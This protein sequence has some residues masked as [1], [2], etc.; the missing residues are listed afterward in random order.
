MPPNRWPRSRHALA[1]VARPAH[2]ALALVSD[3]RW[4]RLHAL[5]H[6][7]YPLTCPHL[8]SFCK[9]ALWSAW[10]R[11]VS[12]CVSWAC[13]ASRT[14]VLGALPPFPGPPAGAGPSGCPPSCWS[15]VCCSGW[16]AS[17]GVG[18]CLGVSET[19]GLLFCWRSCG[20]SAR[21]V[22]THSLESVRQSLQ[23]PCRDQGWAGTAP[24]GSC[25]DGGSQRHAP[26]RPSSGESR[27]CLMSPS[28][29]LGHVESASVFC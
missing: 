20:W 3:R 27:Q 5:W 21:R 19:S 22:A 17:A 29:P 12:V 25:G 16:T 13:A 2:A 23:K 28:T 15:R 7:T 14:P 1:S 8:A 24:A 9:R 4:R 11:R 6:L 26:P 18:L 10:L